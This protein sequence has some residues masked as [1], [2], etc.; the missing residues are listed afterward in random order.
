MDTPRKPG[1]W[2][3]PTA[4][5]PHANVPTAK[6]H[7]VFDGKVK[8]AIAK[9]YDCAPWRRFKASVLVYNPQCQRLVNGEQCQEA[10]AVVH[11][12]ISPRVNQT[13]FMDWQN[14]VCVCAP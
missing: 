9:L 13:L 1:S 8:D 10:A 2:A 11:H 5:L 14:V 12:I 4:Q 3:P 7:N 6:S